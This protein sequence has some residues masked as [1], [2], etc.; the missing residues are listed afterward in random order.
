MAKNEIDPFMLKGQ[1]QAEQLIAEA[2]EWMNHHG[3]EEQVEIFGALA[4]AAE[5]P[6][7]FRDLKEDQLSAVCMF[8]M[9]GYFVVADA[10]E[11]GRRIRDAHGA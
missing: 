1:A 5:N 10:M 6:E 9:I 7:P 4:E 2:K 8:T 3:H 11:R